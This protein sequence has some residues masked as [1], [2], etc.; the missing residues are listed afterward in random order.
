MKKSKNNDRQ[1]RKGTYQLEKILAKGG[2]GQTWKAKVT[3]VKRSEEWLVK[4]GPKVNDTVIIKWANIQDNYAPSENLDFLEKVNA[5]INKELST[6]EKLSDLDCVARIYDTG[7]IILQLPDGSIQASIFLVEQY[8][9]GKMF[10]KHLLQKFGIGVSKEKQFSGISNADLFLEYAGQLTSVVRDIHYRGV[11]HGDIWQNNII[12]KKQGDTR[13]Y[14]LIDFGSS[15]IRNTA[16]LKPDSLARE[17]RDNYVAPERKNGERHGRRS[18]IYSLGGL[19]YFMATGQDPPAPISEKEQLKNTIVAD[20]EK[21]NKA[22][23]ESNC[24]IADIIARCLRYYKD[25]RIRDA[26]ALLNEIRLFSFSDTYL[27][28]NGFNNV[29]SGDGSDEQEEKDCARCLLGKDCDNDNLFTRKLRMDCVAFKS[30]AQDMKRGILEISGDHE[31]IVL[32]MSA[33][34]SVLVEG[35][36]FLVKSTPRFWKTENMGVNGRFLSMVKLAAQRGVEVKSIMLVCEN[37]RIVAENRNISEAHLTAMRQLKK[38]T[39]NINLHFY[40]LPVS[41]DE[42]H[43]QMREKKWET[44][45]VIS[46]D[47]VKAVQPVFDQK[48]ILQTVRFIRE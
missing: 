9:S 2:F 13:K 16:A 5:T 22:L 43:T 36:I 40:C 45:Y 20:M 17:R 35:D 27:R 26:D 29:D 24:G 12:V 10:D 48:D 14:C 6:L 8:L 47:R 23:I 3:R 46:Q 4:P 30:R 32:G 44:C 15:A 34:L 38:S 41:A 19:F 21:Y 11:I 7:Q 42:Q 39:G 18:D 37:D 28:H 33:F 31:E 25:E 1:G